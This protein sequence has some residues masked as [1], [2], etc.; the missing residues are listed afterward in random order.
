MEV[1]TMPDGKFIGIPGGLRL[2]TDAVLMDDR[3]FRD[4]DMKAF[5]PKYN[6]YCE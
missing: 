2:L 6:D 5:L 4:I 3:C 1:E